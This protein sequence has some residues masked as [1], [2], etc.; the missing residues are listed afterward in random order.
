MAHLTLSLDLYSLRSQY[1][2]S[3]V[4]ASFCDWTFQA[5]E[6]KFEAHLRNPSQL[7]NYGLTSEVALH[8]LN[9]FLQ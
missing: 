6:A 8:S 9:D 2:S 7:H 5:A 3:R 1:N 4:P